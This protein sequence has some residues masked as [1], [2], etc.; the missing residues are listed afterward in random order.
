[1][2]LPGFTETL[3]KWGILFLFP[4]VWAILSEVEGAAGL[5]VSKM[6]F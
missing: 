6:C 1:M 3:G 4:M 2:T 5:S